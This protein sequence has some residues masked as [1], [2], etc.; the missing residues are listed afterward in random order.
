VGPD[1]I[2]L[3]RQARRIPPAAVVGHGARAC[4]RQGI[5]APSTHRH[6]FCASEL[7]WGRSCCPFCRT[8][9]RKYIAV[10]GFAGSRT[11]THH[12]DYDPDHGGRAG[13]RC[14]Y[15]RVVLTP[16]GADPSGPAGLF[17]QNTAA[18]LCTSS[19]GRTGRCARGEGV[20]CSIRS[21]WVRDDWVRVRMCAPGGLTSGPCSR[22]RISLG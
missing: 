17:A 22:H 13:G 11:R 10:I 7:D 6:G 20:I 21:Y 8:P 19:R 15:L 9:P 3:H 5:S 16:T 14:R 4:A 1:G 12:R 2:V 18:G